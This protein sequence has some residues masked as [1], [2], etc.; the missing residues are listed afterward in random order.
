M[1]KFMVMEHTHGLTNEYIMDNGK[2]VL[3][4][5]MA[6]IFMKMGLNMKVSISLIRRKDSVFI[7][8]QIVANISDGGRKVNNMGLVLILLAMNQLK[9]VD[10]G[11]LE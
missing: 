1:I 11:N 7:C 9:K 3:C 5:V 2:K 10:F 8:G 4:M 6:S